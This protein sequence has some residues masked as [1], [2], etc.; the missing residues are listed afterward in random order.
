MHDE[1]LKIAGDVTSV[2]ILVG[3]LVNY[4]PTIAAVISIVWGLIRLIETDTFQAALYHVTGWDMR[5]WLDD[6]PSKDH[7]NEK[8]EG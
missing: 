5:A 6:R 2:G 3:T 8:D 7:R 1:P 4:L